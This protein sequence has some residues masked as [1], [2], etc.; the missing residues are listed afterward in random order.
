MLNIK[1]LL[2]PTLFQTSNDS[3]INNIIFSYN[4]PSFTLKQEFQF[5]NFLWKTNI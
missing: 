1:Y 3:N 5:K 4:S 2:Q